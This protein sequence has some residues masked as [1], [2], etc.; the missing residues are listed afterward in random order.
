MGN[1]SK[2]KKSTSC[3]TSIFSPITAISELSTANGV[4]CFIKIM[5]MSNGVRKSFCRTTKLVLGKMFHF[6]II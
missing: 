6:L 4:L 1:F 3:L 5:I 2:I